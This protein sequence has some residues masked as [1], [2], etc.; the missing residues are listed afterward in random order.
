MPRT[1][2]LLL[3]LSLLFPACSPTER[4]DTPLIV[5]SIAPLGSWISAV[6][7]DD[8]EVL[9]LLPSTMNPHTFELTPVQLRQAGQ[10]SMIVLNGAGLE[11]WA[12]RLLDNLSDKDIPVVT[13]SDFVDLLQVGH[14]HEA[15]DHRGHDHGGDHQRAHTHEA[16]NPHFWL[17]PAI[18]AHSVMR[19]ADRI[20]DILP[21]K[22]DSIIARAEAY[23]L[24]LL[25]LDAEIAVEVS[26]WKQHR[27]IGDHSAWVYFARR[28]DLEEA[29]VIEAIP[30]REISARALADLIALMQSRQVNVVF[31]DM[32]NASRAADI[33]AEETGARLVR[34]DPIGAVESDY[35]DIMRFNVSEMA[36]VM[37]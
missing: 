22:R 12:S 15:H 4:G 6:G 7:G 3:A 26:T 30:G 5:T 37:Q 21:E 34:L 16:G 28:Y 8:V 1:I 20:A 35:I 2:F 18:A 13:L 19:I 33:L 17:D 25:E 9:I 14:E 29:G 11:F 27:F 32:R 23:R 10:A 24:A 31:S 36:K